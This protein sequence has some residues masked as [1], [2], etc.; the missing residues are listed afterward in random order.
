MTQSDDLPKPQPAAS[1]DEVM[2]IR[3]EVR[4]G[5]LVETCEVCGHFSANVDQVPTSLW[6]IC[7]EGG[8]LVIRCASGAQ[9]Y[10]V[11]LRP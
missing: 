2:K 9:S 5:A 10:T 3:R 1:A 6:H 7:K 8:Q 4:D 11:P